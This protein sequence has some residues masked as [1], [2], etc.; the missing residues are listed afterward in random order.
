MSRRSSI[1]M[2]DLINW[3]SASGSP[4]SAKMSPLPTWTLV[5]SARAMGWA[6]VAVP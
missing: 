2:F 5:S 3:S 6:M 1:T 4:K